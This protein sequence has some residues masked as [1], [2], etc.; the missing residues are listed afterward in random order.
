[1]LF[2]SRPGEDGREANE[3]I[4]LKEPYEATGGRFEEVARPIKLLPGA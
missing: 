1:M 4:A 3:T 2:R